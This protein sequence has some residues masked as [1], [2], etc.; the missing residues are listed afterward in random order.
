M[1]IEHPGRKNSQ[2]QNRLG[3]QPEKCIDLQ[4]KLWIN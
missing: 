1:L 4:L 3:I 2:K